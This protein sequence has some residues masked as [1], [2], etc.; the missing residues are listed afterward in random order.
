MKQTLLIVLVI[1]A[2]S[3]YGQQRNNSGVETYSGLHQK[4]E[5]DATHNPGA[6][7][8][9]VIEENTASANAAWICDTFIP[10]LCLLLIL[11]L[12]LTLPGHAK[13]RS[14]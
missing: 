5:T 10:P 14:S 7:S 2:I 3:A 6:D 11:W 9:K 4:N 1:L 12:A 13:G 8:K